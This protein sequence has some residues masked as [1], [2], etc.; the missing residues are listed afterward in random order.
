M[1]PLATRAPAVRA[2]TPTAPAMAD[3]A[4]IRRPVSFVRRLVCSRTTLAFGT[5]TILALLFTLNTWLAPTTRYIGGGADPIQTVWAINWVPFSLGHG[6]DPLLTNYVNAPMG[7]D[8]LWNQSEAL[9]AIVLWPVTALMGSVFT[10]NLLTLVGIALSAFFAFLAVRRYVPNAWAAWVAGLLYGFS[11]FV[12]GQVHGH[13]NL[14]LGA[15][16]VPLALMLFDELVIRQ[17]MRARTLAPLLI[18]FGVVQF[19]VSQEFLL[20]SVIIAAILV[21][22]LKLVSRTDRTNRGRY[23]L[24]VGGPA[25]AMLT[26]LLAV[27]AALQLAGPNAVSGVLHPIGRYVSDIVNLIVPTSVQLIRPAAVTLTATHFTGNAAEWDAYVGIP[28]ILLLIV[29]ALVFRRVRLVTV[30]S[31]MAVVATLLSLGPTLHVGGNDTGIPLPWWPLAHLPVVENVLPNRLMAFTFLAVA[32]V[33]AYTLSRLARR[34]L[35]GAITVGAV[36]MLPLFPA[37]PANSASVAIPSF[38]TGRDVAALPDGTV[39]LVVPWPGSQDAQAMLWQVA[40]GMRFRLL[41]GY[42]LGPA[43]PESSGL[44]QVV[45]AMEAGQPPP[46]L[47]NAQRDEYAGEISSAHVGVILMGLGHTA[48]QRSIDMFFTSLLREH[49]RII[50]GV[51]EWLVPGALLPPG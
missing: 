27:P 36:V 33:L 34:S 46:R 32:L 43:A 4:A 48:H 2:F 30:A 40:S 42:F 23:V 1:S 26:V 13:L 9:P 47:T 18:V 16:T 8:L 12:T 20:T 29:A 22:A 15:A 31:L 41:G 49:P 7:I 50:D 5:Y 35:A 38:F 17:R 21:L 6:A 19:L 14:V 24:K 37:V 44:R 39:A 45:G 11:P 10:F 28:L 51:D 3:P 25:F